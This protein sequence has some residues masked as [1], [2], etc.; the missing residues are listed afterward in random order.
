MIN[1][2]NI[3]KCHNSKILLSYKDKKSSEKNTNNHLRIVNV[4]KKLMYE[5]KK[6]SNYDNNVSKGLTENEIKKRIAVQ[7]TTFKIV[8]IKR[9]I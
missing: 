1:I 3:I 8:Q 2:E 7:K 4:E 5:T 9:T 6:E